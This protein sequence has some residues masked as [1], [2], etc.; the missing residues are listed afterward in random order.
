MNREEIV[1]QIKK[2]KNRRLKSRL[3]NYGSL[4]SIFLT[5]SIF[6][7]GISLSSFVSFLII[8]PLPLYFIRESLKWNRKAKAKQAQL[9][10]LVEAI[11]PVES[12]FSLASFLTQPNMT[13]RLTLILFFLVIFTTI[14]RTRE[15]S[16]SLSQTQINYQ[17]A[18]QN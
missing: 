17:I 9:D 10:S 5:L 8:L 2:Y 14:A 3:A 16:A 6:G 15:S 11:T 7:S 12:K 13:F 18:S 1:S 4:V